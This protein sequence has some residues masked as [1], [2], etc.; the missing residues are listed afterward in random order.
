MWKI[1]RIGK[2]A[3]LIAFQQDVQTRSKAC[4]KP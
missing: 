3:E 1:G 2:I 4:K